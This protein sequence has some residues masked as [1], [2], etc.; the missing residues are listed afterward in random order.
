MV[1]IRHTGA[2]GL[3][4]NDFAGS[5]LGAD[6]QNF[7]FVGAELVNNLQSIV[8][9]GNGLLQV[10]DVD[11]VTGTEDELVHLGVPETGLVT[12]VN[13]GFQHITHADLRSH[14][15][16]LIFQWVKPPYSP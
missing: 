14:N 2:T 5:T 11:L 1:N 3:L 7:V 8:K 10:D 15:R 4:L 16:L 13:T 9:R 12:K 6:K